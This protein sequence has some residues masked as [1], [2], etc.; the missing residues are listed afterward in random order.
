MYAKQKPT[1]PVSKG[2]NRKSALNS[3]HG[4]V[5]LP[6]VGEI[7]DSI[8]DHSGTVRGED[9]NH[10][11]QASSRDGMGCR[12]EKMATLVALER[13]E[14]NGEPD[15]ETVRLEYRGRYLSD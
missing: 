9:T 10:S 7:G 4:V 12:G 11:A 14:S 5:S 1:T 3:K 13:I 6:G 8:D 2:T 15:T